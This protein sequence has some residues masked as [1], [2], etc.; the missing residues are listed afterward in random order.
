MCEFF[1]SGAISSLYQR[2]VTIVMTCYMTFETQEN[3]RGDCCRH[4][5]KRHNQQSRLAQECRK[6][7]HTDKPT[8]SVTSSTVETPTSNPKVK[9]SHQTAHE[10]IPT[11][12]SQASRRRLEIQNRAYENM[13]VTRHDSG[14]MTP[15]VRT[16]PQGSIYNEPVDREA[17]RQ[18]DKPSSADSNL[19]LAI[20]SPGKKATQKETPRLAT[21]AVAKPTQNSK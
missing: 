6:T 18:V 3:S 12:R 20:T 7:W 2:Y 8:L 16:S 21:A 14:K 1:S 5:G 15:T 17:T 10:T 11:N 9:N 4:R 19:H 13:E